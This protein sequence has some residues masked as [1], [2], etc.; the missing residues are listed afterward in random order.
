MK[1]SILP[2]VQTQKQKQLFTAK[3]L[4]VHLNESIAQ[5]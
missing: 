2:L 4:T 3:I 5:Q 1:Q